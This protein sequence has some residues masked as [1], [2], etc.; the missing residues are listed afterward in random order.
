MLRETSAVLLEVAMPLI[1]IFA[2]F[3]GFSFCVLEAL[4][5]GFNIRSLV[6]NYVNGSL[7]VMVA[8]CLLLSL[9]LLAERALGWR[10][11]READL[12]E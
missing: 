6:L 9:R 1:L 5:S 7:S 8:A 10:S 11:R 12:R 4:S 2:G 3:L